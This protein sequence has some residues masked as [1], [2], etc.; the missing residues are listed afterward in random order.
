[1]TEIKKYSTLN[2]PDGSSPGSGISIVNDIYNPILINSIKHKCSTFSFSATSLVELTSGL[3]GFIENGGS[4]Q[5]VFGQVIS[6]KEE[7]SIFIGTNI[8]WI[9]FSKCIKNKFIG[10]LFKVSRLSM[11]VT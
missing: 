8:V 2:L 7:K 3:E 4:M 11:H 9:M 1:M 10:S 5:L 6:P